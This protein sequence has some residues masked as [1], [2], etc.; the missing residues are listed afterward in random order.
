MKMDTYDDDPVDPPDFRIAHA[1]FLRRQDDQL[2]DLRQAYNSFS[3]AERVTIRVALEKAEAASCN[4]AELGIRLKVEVE[5]DERDEAGNTVSVGRLRVQLGGYA[6]GDSRVGCWRRVHA[7]F[8]LAVSA[9]LQP[10]RSTL[11]I[12]HQFDVV[13][14]L[15]RIDSK[16]EQLAVIVVALHA[17]TNAER[18]QERRDFLLDDSAA[19]QVSDEVARRHPANYPRSTTLQALQLEPEF[20]LQSEN[21]SLPRIGLPLP[22]K[23]SRPLLLL[24]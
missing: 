24:G 13:F 2:A 7:G 19:T 4:L 16:L 12:R 21:H 17:L 6:S 23:A 10:D 1:R 14:L 11:R 5:N 18:V 20:T 15:R 8:V 3:P 9:S 22:Y